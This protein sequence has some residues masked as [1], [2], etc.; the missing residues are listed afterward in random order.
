MKFLSIFFEC[1]SI[2]YV[3]NRTPLYIAAEK[4]R[5]DI[6]RLLLEHTEIEVNAFSI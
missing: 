5:A 1:N 4:G 3:F 2:I 6:V